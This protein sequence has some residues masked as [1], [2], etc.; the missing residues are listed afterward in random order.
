MDD[1]LFGNDNNE[2]N[3]MVA[4][5][6]ED[7]EFYR[8]RFIAEFKRKELLDKAREK[9]VFNGDDED[10]KFIMD[11]EKDEDEAESFLDREKRKAERKDL[12]RVDHSLENYEP[13]NKSL[14]IETKEVS[15]MSDK[16]VS[17][18]RKINGDIKV[19]GLKCP[20]PISN[21]Y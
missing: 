4:T 12:K 5:S 15:R 16:E 3:N 14:Y 1:I 17:E 13:I 8:Q 21:W 9:I 10:D 7:D 2:D 11:F 18:F 6:A 20:K 19:R